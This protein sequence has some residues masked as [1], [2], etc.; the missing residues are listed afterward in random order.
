MA[1]TVQGSGMR[2]YSAEQLETD[3]HIDLHQLRT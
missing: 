3:F 2:I 1:E